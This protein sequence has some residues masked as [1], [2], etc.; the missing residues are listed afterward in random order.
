MGF[1]A[2]LELGGL[3]CSMRY[4]SR[5]SRDILQYVTVYNGMLW[6]VAVCCIS[7]EV[8]AAQTPGVGAEP[9]QTRAYPTEDGALAGVIDQGFTNF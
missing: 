3:G 5:R 7:A 1:R 4:K 8:E 6:S 2:V 9:M